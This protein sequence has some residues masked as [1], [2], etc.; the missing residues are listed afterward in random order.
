MSQRNRER[1]QQNAARRSSSQIGPSCCSNTLPV[2]AVTAPLMPVMAMRQENASILAAAS[3]R[4]MATYMG[5]DPNTPQQ[6]MLTVLAERLDMVASTPPV[7]FLRRFDQMIADPDENEEVFRRLLGLQLYLPPNEV[8]AIQRQREETA[9]FHHLREMRR[10]MGLAEQ[11]LTAQAGS[12]VN[13]SLVRLELVRGASPHEIERIL[14]D[15]PPFENSN[16]DPQY[17]VK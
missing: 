9:G 4:A 3:I 15:L 11:H 1:R 2:C 16:N 8:A 10:Q 13:S 5:L 6:Q 14:Q 12:Q 7:E 17:I